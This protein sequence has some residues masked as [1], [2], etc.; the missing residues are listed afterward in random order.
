MHQ[1]TPIPEFD[2][3][4]AMAQNNPEQLEALRRQMIEET[5][6]QADESMQRKLHGLQFHIDMEIRRA[7]TPM[8]AC[9]K[10]SEMMHGSLSKLR[11]ALNDQSNQ[12]A[13]TVI[14]TRVETVFDSGMVT[15]ASTQ[16]VASVNNSRASAK[17]LKFT[18]Q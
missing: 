2:Q 8:A 15:N 3:L 4:T 14:T 11:S 17:I 7:K 9:I 12:E 16:P 1:F 13:S 6:S 10:I 18:A 5:I